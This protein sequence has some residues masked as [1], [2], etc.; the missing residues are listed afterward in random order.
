MSSLSEC[1][2]FIHEN[3]FVEKLRKAL[4]ICDCN[5]AMIFNRKL[6][7]PICPKCEP[8]VVDRPET[9]EEKLKRKTFDEMEDEHFEA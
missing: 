5:T 7:K 4:A 9:S 8:N 1:I 6:Q 2:T 3:T